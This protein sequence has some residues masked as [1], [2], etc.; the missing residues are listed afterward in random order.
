MRLPVSQEDRDAWRIARSG[1][2]TASVFRRVMEGKERA[3]RTLAREIAEEAAEIA[4]GVIN[5]KLSGV[6]AIQWG[7]E[8]E[9][10]ARA[11]YTLDTGNLVDDGGLWLWDENLLVGAS[12]DGLV[13]D[14]G[15]V[16]IKCPYNRE[17]HHTYGNGPGGA[18]WQ[19]QGQ[20]M[21]TGRPWADFISY[22]P[23]ERP[24]LQLY[25]V[26]VQR[27]EAMMAAMAVRLHVFVA[28][29][30]APALAFAGVECADIPQPDAPS[31]FP[32]DSDIPNL[33]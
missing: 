20:L 9:P 15:Q 27:D 5:D 4:A 3:W 7:I 19:V 14:D 12:P 22:D 13:D 26:R 28:D 6:P 18:M 31:P 33:F 24:E 30:L 2:V 25:V 11:A 1:K 23:R 16:E 29:F 21:C 17:Q 10:M 32:A 8:H